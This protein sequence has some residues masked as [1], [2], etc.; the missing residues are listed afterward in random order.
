M[1]CFKISPTTDEKAKKYRDK[2]VKMLEM[3][4]W[5]VERLGTELLMCAGLIG[6]IRNCR[7]KRE[8]RLH[9]GI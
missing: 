9:D 4:T 1:S 5:S 6:H 3:D 8:K 7:T 2:K